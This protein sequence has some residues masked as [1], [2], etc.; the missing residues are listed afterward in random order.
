V[1]Q[2]LGSLDAATTLCQRCV[3]SMLSLPASM[4]SSGPGQSGTQFL[5][6]K[7]IQKTSVVIGTGS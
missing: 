5:L 7:A 6:R 4:M 2:L 3:T 1:P